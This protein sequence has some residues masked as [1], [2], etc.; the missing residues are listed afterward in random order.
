MPTAAWLRDVALV[1][2]REAG[3]QVRVATALRELPLISE[4]ILDG[5]RPVE[6]GRVLARRCRYEERQGCW[7]TTFSRPA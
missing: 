1:S 3:R 7:M 4:A 2:G 5:I 6:H